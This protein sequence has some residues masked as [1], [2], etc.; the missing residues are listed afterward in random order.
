MFI[1]FIDIQYV[2]QNYARLTAE[3]ILRRAA[4]DK[5]NVTDKVTL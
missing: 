4:P 2:C 1:I 3:L 5:L